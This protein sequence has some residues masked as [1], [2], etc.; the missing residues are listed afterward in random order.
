MENRKIRFTSGG[1]AWLA[2]PIRRG[3]QR[4]AAKIMRDN[5]RGCLVRICSKLRRGE[6][7]TV[8]GHGMAARERRGG[9]RSGACD[10]IGMSADGW[11]VDGDARNEEARNEKLRGRG[12]TP[13]TPRPLY[14][15]PAL[16]RPKDAAL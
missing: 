11:R 9:Q 7:S 3:K 10:R 12:E 8:P 14:L 13:E 15:L 16:S 5:A 1:A 4:L 6:L 2:Q